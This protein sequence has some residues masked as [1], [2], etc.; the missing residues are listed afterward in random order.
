MLD[1]IQELESKLDFFANFA[2]A[3]HD[4]ATI[5]INESAKHNLESV[6]GVGDTQGGGSDFVIQA[7]P[8]CE[9]EKIESKLDTSRSKPFSMTNTSGLKPF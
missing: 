8:P 3:K 7:P 2:V 5:K 4:F 6:V 9:K 1:S